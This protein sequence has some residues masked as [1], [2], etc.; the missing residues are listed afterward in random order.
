MGKKL[1]VVESPAK[2][3]TINKILGREYI[4]KS[5]VGHVRDLPEKSLGV[6]IKA[7]FK[8]RYVLSKGKKTV[9]SDLRKAARECEAVYLAPDP[10]REGE[11]IAW[12]LQE[13]LLTSTDNLPFL[14]VRYNEITP[15]AVREA[16]ENP[17][18]IDMNRVN[19]QQARR[20]LD[21]IVGYTVSPMLWRRMK[22]GLSAGRV[23]SVALRLVCEREDEIRNFKPEEY[24]I[25]GATVRKLIV[26]LDPFDVKLVKIDGEKPEIK[27]AQ[28]E[29]A[30]KGD[31]EGRAMR[32]AS[33]A[34]R[35]VRRKAPP[36]FITSSLQQAASNKFRFSPKRTM[37]VAQKLYEGVDFGQGSVGLITYM[38]TDSFSVSQEAIASCREFIT[39]EIGKEYCPEKPNFFKSRGSAQEAHEAIRPTDIS[40]T[41]K[42][43]KGRL[44]AQEWKVYALIWERFVASQMA[45]AVIE[46]T[47]AEIEAVPGADGDKTYI[48]RASSSRVQFPGYMKVSGTETGKKNKDAGEVDHLPDLREGEPLEC[49]E[50]LSEQK[51]TTPPARYSEASLVRQL[52]RNGVGRP[53]TY[54]QTLSTL[55][56]R[57]YVTMQKRSLAATD[58]GMQVNDLLTKSL[59]DLF[60]V[61][62]TASMEDMLDSVEQGKTEWTG[63][64]SDFYSKFEK[65]MEA[66]KAPAAN[67]DAVAIVLTALDRV[68]EWVPEVKRGKRTYSDE[69]FVTSIRRDV[70]NASKSISQRQFDA[71][72]RIACRYRDQSE[73]INKAIHDAGYGDLLRDPEFQ[74]P[75]TST[76]KKLEILQGVEMD[77]AAASFVSSLS[78]RV[79]TNRRL[80]EAQL[81]AL[82]NV[83]LSHSR[84]IED[85]ETK[86]G[87]LEIEIS[88]V[89]Q[90]N[91]S[92][93]LLE[94][95]GRVQEWKPPIARGKR[96]FNDKAFFESLKKHHDSKGFLSDRQRKALRRMVERYSSAIE[97]YD[98]VAEKLNLKSARKN[99]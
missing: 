95:M 18:E 93:P 63:M 78:A 13:L 99:D 36:P 17:G 28:Q 69:K 50:W 88:E 12:H 55:T 32:V 81:K 3:K 20:I 65:W 91:E 19:A 34:T 62:F 82:N 22:R 75:R 97:G 71:L 59:G 87:E 41:P 90:D 33:T 47:S 9:V 21:R 49:L 51:E 4:V 68:K 89:E 26:P 11:A 98:D 35:Q 23:Q 60:D 86:R 56:Q 31:L 85:F 66:T 74:P 14:R 64:L 40:Q 70:E 44:E 10:D 37:G 54:A 72:I 27:T 77:D 76:V 16:F 15:R 24:W 38:R 84:L 43:L 45:Q 2:A 30:V 8:P 79:Q 48:F 96:V 73:E 58:L 1:V 39:R 42:R 5:S 92:G 52:E 7:G 67:G 57:K 94:A 25:I 80:T 53:S 6:D 61:G 83:V 46:Q 29:Q